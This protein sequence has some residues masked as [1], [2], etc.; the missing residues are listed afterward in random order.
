MANRRL[1]HEIDVDGAAMPALLTRPDGDGDAPGLVLVQEIF[2]VSDYIAW[3]ADRLNRLGYVV[4][5]P[6]LYWRIEPRIDL[7]DTDLDEAFSVSGKLDPE[8]AVGDVVATLGALRE[9]DGVSGAGL[10]GFCLGG[11]LAYHAAAAADPDVCVS[12][13]GSAIPDALD[14]MD[15]LDCPTLFHFGERDEYC[16]VASVD[17]VEQAAATNPNTRFERYPGGGHAFDNAFS[18]RFHQPRNA[19]EAWG[20]TGAFLQQHL[21]PS[22]SR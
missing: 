7:D 10:L 17:A 9:T 3:T 19:A 8:R 6:D 20:V 16:P 21:P 5:V 15:R 1:N 4:L 11:V 14:A 12:Y 2:G 13:Y 18:N 22:P